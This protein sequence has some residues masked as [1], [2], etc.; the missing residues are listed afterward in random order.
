MSD[1]E[2]KRK[3]KVSLS[4]NAPVELPYT[5]FLAAEEIG[6]KFA[7]VAP[8][9]VLA[10]F[11]A[12]R[13]PFLEVPKLPRLLVEALELQQQANKDI[14]ALMSSY[15]VANLQLKNILDQYQAYNRSLEAA[16]RCWSECE[17]LIPLQIQTVKNPFDDWSQQYTQLYTRILHEVKRERKTVEQLFEQYKVCQRVKEA[18]RLVSELDIVV[19][20]CDRLHKRLCSI[21]R[22]TS[23]ETV[24]SEE[25]ALETI[26]QLRQ[27]HSIVD[28][29][30]EMIKEIPLTELDGSTPFVVRTWRRL[31]LLSEKLNRIDKELVRIFDILL[32]S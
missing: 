21:E 17:E 22:M 7:K 6:Q 24:S 29:A 30:L 14:K 25:W 2:K 5:F 23:R 20:E 31:R 10:D 3:E 11:S 27:E 12:E 9:Q 16:M 4:F 18:D 19:M 13:Y 32:Q 1:A 8:F 26:A 15:D 28:D